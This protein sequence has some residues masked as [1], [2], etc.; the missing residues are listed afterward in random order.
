VNEEDGKMFPWRAWA[1]RAFTYI[2][3]L[4][5]NK[6]KYVTDTINGYRAIKKEAFN[7]LNLDAPG[8]AI[9]YQM[10]IRAM[11]AGLKIAEIPTVEGQRIGGESTA[12][13]IPTGI[14]FVKFLLREM[15]IGNKF[16]NI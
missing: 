12:K 9:E 15:M 4:L 10:S 7:L 1:N 14:L 11:K 5:W 6:G 16:L 8:F 2:A 13:S 3:N